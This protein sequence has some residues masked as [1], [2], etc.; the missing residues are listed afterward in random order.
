[1]QQVEAVT[2]NGRIR[3]AFGLALYEAR[4]AAD[5]S[6]QGLG[7]KVGVSLQTVQSWETGR[8]F[9]EKLDVLAK[10]GKLLKFDV[11]AALN[12]ALKKGS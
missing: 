2:A 7:E 5:Y 8:T 11:G 4:Q 6:R 1:M 10:V 9:P 3:C 12:A